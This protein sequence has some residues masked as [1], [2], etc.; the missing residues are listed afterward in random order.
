MVSL[1]WDSGFRVAIY[2]TK[3]KRCPRHQNE[4]KSGRDRKKDRRKKKE[5]I[6]SK[7]K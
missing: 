1:S 6:K 7:K 3:N 2:N 4:G 5:E